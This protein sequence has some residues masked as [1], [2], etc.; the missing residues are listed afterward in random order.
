MGKKSGLIGIFLVLF[1]VGSVFAGDVAYV[2]KSS[3]KVDDNILGV[4]SG[5]GMKVDLISGSNLPKDFSSYRLVFV[6]DESFSKTIPV[7]EGN[8]VIM[9][10]YECYDFGLTN[11]NGVSVMS[12]RIP[13]EV[14]HNGN[15]VNVYNDVKDIY[16]NYLSYYF[17]GIDNK[18]SSAET[19]AF[20]YSTSSGNSGDVVSFIEKGEKLSNGKTADGN[21][22]FFGIY[23]TD[24]WTE[25]SKELFKDCINYAYDSSS[26]V[27]NQTNETNTTVPPV[28]NPSSGGGGGGASFDAGSGACF[29]DWSCSAWNE[30]K[31]GKQTRICNY[32]STACPPSQTK[33]AEEQSCI[34]TPQT[35]NPIENNANNNVGNGTTPSPNGLSLITGAVIG[36]FSRRWLWIWAIA[37]LIIIVAVYFYVVAKRKKK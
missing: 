29:T 10:H 17:L 5:L 36:A 8:Y 24:Y 13:L 2:Y 26:S 15:S 25:D 14:T 4:F 28:V 7:Y 16:G 22:C 27:S 30:C 34:E 19:N 31:N 32:P 35:N 18:V 20:T 3:I 11:R 21:I 1:L 37:F 23:K 9:N 33:P 6:G 12:S